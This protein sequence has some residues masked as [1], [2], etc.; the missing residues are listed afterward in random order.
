MRPPTPHREGTTSRS[1]PVTGRWIEKSRDVRPRRREG[2]APRG[3]GRS[4]LRERRAR[5]NPGR[6]LQKPLPNAR[7]GNP[8]HERADRGR[9]RRP[10][11][12]LRLAGI[13]GP[14]PRGDGRYGRRRGRGQAPAHLEC[15]EKYAS[16]HGADEVLPLICGPPS[17][18][19]PSRWVSCAPKPLSFLR[20]FDGITS[21]R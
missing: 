17:R 21:S 19:R 12:R 8:A 5:P 20:A 14:P 16:Y 15:G 1:F 9:F 10:S 7:T 2:R 6:R 18:S 4:R 11:C 13:I 3:E